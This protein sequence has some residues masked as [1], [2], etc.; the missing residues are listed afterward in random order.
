MTLYLLVETVP[1]SA[2]TVANQLWRFSIASHS[3]L[4]I[5]FLH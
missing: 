5:R 1:C 2:S 4:P 3:G